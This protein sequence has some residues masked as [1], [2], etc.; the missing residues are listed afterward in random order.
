MA[1]DSAFQDVRYALRAAVTAP[2]WSA[3]V[4]LSLA[5]GIGA[6]TAIFSVVDGVL[7]KSLPVRDQDQLLVVWTSRPE[8]GFDH[9]PFSSSRTR[10][11]AIALRTASG[12]AAHPYAG[13]LGGVVH[14]ADGSALPVQ[15]TAVTG[16]WFQVLGVAARAGRLLNP[17]D[18]RIGA[19]SVVVLSTQ[20]GRAPVW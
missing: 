10:G 5:L 1:F 19:P 4:I 11:S 2:A 3:A 6:A 15:Q 13:T 8:R 14:V 18:D 9:W 20:D 7:L 17:A 16:N 12:V